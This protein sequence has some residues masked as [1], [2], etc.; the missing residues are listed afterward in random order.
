MSYNFILM[1]LHCTPQESNVIIIWWKNDRRLDKASFELKNVRNTCWLN[2]D[3]DRKLHDW[4]WVKQLLSWYSKNGMM[5]EDSNFQ[6]ELHYK[7]EMFEA[8]K[9]EI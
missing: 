4:I 3:I 2:D 5:T 8:S 7:W 1:I 9:T 6:A